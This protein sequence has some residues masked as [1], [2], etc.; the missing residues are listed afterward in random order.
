MELKQRHI[1]IDTR[2]A[3]EILNDVIPQ[4]YNKIYDSILIDRKDDIDFIYSIDNNQFRCS[5]INNNIFKNNLILIDT[6]FPDIL[7]YLL[8]K[9]HKTRTTKISE[10]ARLVTIENPLGYDYTYCQDFYYHK[11]KRFLFEL[12][13]GMKSSDVWHGNHYSNGFINEMANE[14]ICYHA[15]DINQF[16]NYLFNNSYLETTTEGSSGKIYEEN[17]VQLLKLNLQVR[18]S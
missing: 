16:E 3:S 10:L 9:S 14:T 7:S 12:A 2:G 4:H 15:F 17:G 18:I 11:V 13:L 6:L 5:T 8:I 1:L